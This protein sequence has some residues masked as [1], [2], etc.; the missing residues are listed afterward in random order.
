MAILGQDYLIT[1]FDETTGRIVIYIIATNQSFTTEL[2]IVNGKFITG[3][4]LGTFL[5]RCYPASQ[6]ARTKE[7]RA[8]VISLREEVRMLRGE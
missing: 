4:A 2:P 5:D 1:G 7:L 8:E 6:I 3:D